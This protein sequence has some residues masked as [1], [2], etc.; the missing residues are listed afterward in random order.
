MD[1]KLIYILIIIAYGIYSSYA[2]SKKEAERK[3]AIEEKKLNPIGGNSTKP[4]IE[5]PVPTGNSW[6]ELIRNITQETKA[7]KQVVKTQT[8]A[9]KSQAAYNKKKKSVQENVF[10]AMGDD[11]NNPNFQQ[12]NNPALN[13]PQ[14]TISDMYAVKSYDIKEEEISYQLNAREALIQSVILTRPNY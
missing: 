5:K 4:I 6:E 9:Q 10:V 12:T 3:K 13:K 1:G 8:T 7:K 2:K 11:S 14:V